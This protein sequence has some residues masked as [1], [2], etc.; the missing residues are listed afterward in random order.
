MNEISHHS[1]YFYNILI[2]LRYYNIQYNI[3]IY[4]YIK[5]VFQGYPA[6]TLTINKA[7]KR[8]M[9]VNNNLK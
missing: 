3:D 5:Q 1:L 9:L 7:Q 4:I 6:V 2:T 8:S